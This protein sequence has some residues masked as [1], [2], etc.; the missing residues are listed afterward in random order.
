MNDP[1][2]TTP[3]T[4]AATTSLRDLL[5]H[6]WDQA[7]RPDARRMAAETNLAPGL[8]TSFLTSTGFPGLDETDAMARAVAPRAWHDVLIRRWHDTNAQRRSATPL[9]LPRHPGPTTAVGAALVATTHREFAEALTR[10][11]EQRQL[12]YEQ[13]AKNSDHFVSKSAA[14]RFA[15]SGRND[16]QDFVDA[17]LRACGVD[18]ID[19]DLWLTAWRRVNQT[20]GSP[21]AKAAGLGVPGG[22]AGPTAPAPRGPVPEHAH[23]PVAQH[24]LV[25]L[26]AATALAGSAAAA[27]Q[28]CRPAVA[29]RWLLFIGLSSAGAVLLILLSELADRRHAARCPRPGC[30]TAPPP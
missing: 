16:K 12:T 15:S 7:G 19:L 11:K 21:R 22:E 23:Q 14:Q 29:Q 5:L 3:P 17:F 30:A 26:L 6:Y 1:D 2:P 24:R 18:D 8:F 27:T 20:T 25:G 9:P 4:V 28:L 10:L 13:I